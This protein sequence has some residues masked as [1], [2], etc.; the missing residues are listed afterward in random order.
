MTTGVQPAPLPESRAPT[1][2]NERIDYATLLSGR[3]KA[4]I[5]AGVLMG[6]LL[7]ALDQT[8]VSTA[9]PR[10]VA[11]LQG[12]DLIAWVSTAYLLA[13]TTM[14]PVY[15]KL[16]D[17]YGR[18]PILLAG[19]GIFLAGSALCGIAPSML[20]LVAFRAVQGVG[21][22]AL[23]S[24]AFAVPADLFAPAERARYQGIF[25]AVFGLSSVIGPYL[26]GLLTDHVGWRWVFYI[27]LPLG[28]IA[29]LFILSHMPRLHSGLRARV[30]W[31]GAGLLIATVLPLLLALTTDKHAHGWT[32]PLVLGM[33][34]LAAVSGVLFVIAERRAASPI[35]PFGLFRLP[36]FSLISVISLLSGATFFGGILFLS[37]FLVNVLGVSAT[38]AGTALMPLSLSMV[39]ASIASSVI[40]QRTGRYKLPVLIGMVV[41]GLALYSLTGLSRETTLMGV[42]LRMVLL[43]L[44][45][46]PSLPIL[47]LALQNAV[48]FHE[49]GS[50]TASRQFFQQL[51]QALGAAIFGAVLSSTLTSAIDTNLAPVR[52]RIPPAM[53]ARFDAGQLR[54]GPVGEGA[55]PSVPIEQRIEQGIRHGFAE[56]RA[57]I[58]L[59]LGRHDA[60][61]TRLL[62]ADPSLPPPLRAAL[63]RGPLDAQLD[64]ALAAVQG[65]LRSGDPEVLAHLANEP[66]L[67]AGLRAELSQ[68][69]PAVL[70]DPAAR[71]AAVTRVTE[72]LQTLRTRASEQALVHARA[73]LD[74]A[75]QQAL[76]SGR[77][78][79]RD[80]HVGIA[81][82]FVTSVTRIYWWAIPLAALAFLLMCF[83]PEIP[84]RR[85]NRPS[86]GAAFE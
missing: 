39:A 13:S 77:E 29:T 85:S 86:P 74:A 10:M 81:E 31:A 12:M 15:G 51:G 68:I 72:A 30:D 61:A 23:T 58:E 44:G 1:E 6:L 27:N 63:D 42:R 38:A 46:G 37:I 70:A 2:R 7:A 64:A 35:I 57:R 3:A 62:L 60:E 78:I 34:A 49:V 71:E 20:A 24:T 48:P 9:L 53:A 83:V 21:A 80:I 75:E 8:I 79:G 36:I 16:S 4:F 69:P 43:G 17:L 66:G 52:A 54:N 76:A 56:R 82:A 45:L 26:G 18:K 32:S 19:I 11:D 50:A 67:P 84:L 28:V 55:G 59:A 41:I 40:V 25:G 65:A 14:V 73:G 47:T 5:L 22:A 33:F